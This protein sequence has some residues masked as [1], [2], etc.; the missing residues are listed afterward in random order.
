[1]PTYLIAFV[2]SDFE[3]N[4]KTSVNNVLFRAFS[5]PDQ[6]SNTNFG[7]ETAI[8]ALE[9]F[10]NRFDTKYALEKLDQ[11]AL[12]VFNRGGMENYGIIFYREDYFLNQP[13]VSG[14]IIYTRHE[15]V[16]ITSNFILLSLILR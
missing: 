15:A 16:K 1:M 9:L 2:I 6:I 8:E 4:S 11:V 14:K 5:R 3:T 7:L 10:E 12:P 13:S